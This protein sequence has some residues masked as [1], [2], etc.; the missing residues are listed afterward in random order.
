MAG[1]FLFGGARL[2][3]HSTGIC[4]APAKA[5]AVDRS[6]VAARFDASLY[7]AGTVIVLVAPTVVFVEFLK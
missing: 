6:A 4:L 1:S 7:A 5:L 2:H 3:C